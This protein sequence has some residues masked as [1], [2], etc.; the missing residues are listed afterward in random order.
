MPRRQEGYSKD[1]RPLSLGVIDLPAGPGTM[2]PLATA[3]SGE[4]VADVRRLVF[5]PVRD[6]M[7]PFE[8]HAMQ[9]IS[10]RSAA[11]VAALACFATVAG[12]TPPRPNI[13]VILVDDMGFSDL[14]CYGSEIPTPRIDSLAA[15]GLRFS[16]FYNTGRCCP[17]RASLLTGL[18]SHQAGVGHMVEDS[19]LPGYR[20]RLGDSCVTIAEALRGAGYHTSIA[21]KWHVGQNHGVAPWNR[22]FDRSLN[23]AAGGF[24]QAGSPRCDLWLDGEKIAADDSRLPTDWYSTDLWTTF[25]LKFVDDA[26]AAK[27]PFFLYLGHNAPHFP[28]Q[29]PAEEIA[30]FRGRYRAGWD[31]L[32]EERLARQR[33]L[34]LLDD[35]WTPAPRPQAV[36]AW[37]SLP[38]EEQDR[39]DHLMAVYAAVVHRMDKAVGDLVDG[40][41]QR[42]VLDDT[43]ILF[44][45]DNGGNAEA[46]PGGRTEGNPSEARSDWFCGESWAF[47]QN[48]P[49]RKYKHFNHEG[50][51]AT[52]LVVHW[53]AGI[54]ARGEWRHDPG[55]L[56]DILPTCLDA[57]GGEFPGERQGKP[58]IPLEGRSLVPV[59]TGEPIAREALYWEHEGNA[60]VRV[61]D[62]KLVRLGT[63]GPWELYDLEA[64]RTEQHDLAATRPAD[65]ARLAGLWQAWAERVHAVPRPE[66]KRPREKKPKAAAAEGRVPVRPAGMRQP[67]APIAEPPAPAADARRPN[68]LVV[69]ADDLGFSDLG[70]YGGE[71]PTPRLDALAAGG[72]RFTQCY[73]SSR[74]CPSRASLLTGLTPHQA[75]I[76]R[77]V[78]RGSAPGYLGRLADRAVT[79]AEVLRPAGYATFAVGKWHVNVPG[80]TERGFDE[81]Y[82]F[83]HGYAVDAFDPRMMT[84]LP[85]GQA[86]RAYAPDAFYA[87]HAITDHALEFLDGARA[88]GK[89]WL[90][91]VGYQCPHFPVQA[92]PAATGRHVERYA[93]GWDTLR[94][95]RLARMKQLGLVTPDLPLP[96]RAPIDSPDVARRIGS[97]TADGLNPAWDSLPDDRRADLAHRM[98]AYAAAVELMD[99][100]VGRLV[101][102]LAA[103]AELEHTLIL[104]LSDN[105]ACGEWEPFG[106]DLDA[107]ASRD[108]PPGHGID[109]GTPGRPNQLH[110]G[111]ELATMGGPG[112]LFSYGCGWANLCNTPLARYKHF[113]HEGGI[114]TPLIVHWPA[115]IPAR[116]ECRRDAAHVMDVMATC[117]EVCGAA[118]PPPGIDREIL[119]LEGR[120]L[121]PTFA[122]DT[123]RPRTLLFEHGGNVAIRRGDWKL[124]ANRALAADGLRADVRWALHDLAADPAEQVDLA[125]DRPDLVAEL[126]AEFLAGARRTLI[127]PGPR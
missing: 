87:T 10:L 65:A 32:R 11:R 93:R 108:R 49:F 27:Q 26:I 55:H 116:G 103:H 127:L 58:S 121:A 8:E 16:Q 44:L 35:R 43:L 97:L 12:A 77:F 109:G 78:G 67:G 7:L 91:Y 111:D 24:Y 88:A 112:S 115:G 84:R 15:G 45:S 117:V 114:R 122:A 99:A 14:G 4:Q 119:P 73:N 124:V 123:G 42:G 52:P 83:V 63:Q 66:Q 64:D 62:L 20:G 82:G 68:V 38:A 125:A 22:G 113:A 23:A 28:L 71:I 126:A 90:L 95:E 13:V 59:F 19:G 76:G 48:V 104:F 85:Q 54:T 6:S 60:A 75:G 50:G 110:T 118:Y 29:A 5:V 72:L 53:P 41:K 47:L 33:K 74:C 120:S 31:A 39:F 92:P 100:D 56:I 46:G 34:G 1:F 70:C 106:F 69:L 9:I 37:E 107:D 105:G 51:I 25:G 3:I 101:D 21:G 102:S 61:G 57:A 96:P 89:P 98:A 40:L 86:A 30:K 36:A 18:Y 80:P 94:A 81:F 17:T 79:L 2:V